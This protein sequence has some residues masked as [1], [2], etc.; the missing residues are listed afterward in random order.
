MT[1]DD[2]S[3]APAPAIM[4]WNLRG[5]WICVDVPGIE[6]WPWRG[7]EGADE[8]VA[9]EVPSRDTGAMAIESKPVV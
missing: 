4:E 2:T 6:I 3:P 1:I 5:T 9:S 8:V 7:E